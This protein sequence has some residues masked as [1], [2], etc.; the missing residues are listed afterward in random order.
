VYWNKVY[1]ARGEERRGVSGSMIRAS[2]GGEKLKEQ[3]EMGGD[4]Y[5]AIV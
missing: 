4:R 2:T 3:E 1:E 5:A